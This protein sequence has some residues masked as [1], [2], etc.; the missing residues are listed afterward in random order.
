MSI[1]IRYNYRVCNTL[2]DAP[3]LLNHA[4]GKLNGIQ[5]DLVQLVKN[6]VMNPGECR[7][8]FRIWSGKV[9]CYDGLIQNQ[10]LASLWVQGI[11]NKGS[12]C[13]DFNKFIY[14]AL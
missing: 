6:T 9:F 4:T 12:N 1:N 14:S 7:D 13:T 8:D 5:T 3:V 11:N 2:T 10:S